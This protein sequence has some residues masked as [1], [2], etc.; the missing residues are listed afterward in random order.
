ML[1]ILYD[2]MS[3]VSMESFGH[4]FPSLMHISDPHAMSSNPT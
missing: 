2:W 4:P 3:V 1:K